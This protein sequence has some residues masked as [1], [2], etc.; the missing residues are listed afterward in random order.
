M[1]RIGLIDLDAEYNK[2]SFPNLCLMKISA[3]W[4]KR[5]AVVEWYDA[6][7]GKYDIVYISK[8]FS[9][10]P[11]TNEVINADLVYKG[12]T[13]YSIRLINSKEQY[14]LPQARTLRLKKNNIH[15]LYRLPEQIE[16]IYPDY[17]IYKGFEGKAYGYLTRGC[18]RNCD[19][20]HVGQKEGLKSYKVANLCD[21][22]RGQKEI[23]LLDP[24]ILAC[25]DWKPLLQQLIDSKAY[26]DF[27]QGLDI[28]LMTK[29]KAEM[30]SQIHC[31]NIHFAWDR[32]ED[33][34]LV[35][36]K[37]KLFAKYRFIAGN[38]PD[39]HAIVYVLVNNGSDFE[40]EDLQRIYMLRELGYWAYV[41]IYDKEHADRKYI[42]LQRWVNNRFVFDTVKR[43]EDYDE[44]KE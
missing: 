27:S 5:K 44:R 38:N 29:E 34:D 4:K 17:S 24:N 42:R 35:L 26:V 12:G 11:D 9:F 31:K 23:V 21:F 25:K 2:V 8:V 19:F 16:H 22:W 1:K 30:I 37:L 28:R 18:P 32:W 39:H 3:Y 14:I 33:K 36:P 7:S 15:Y 6:F 43:F 41:M 10:T 20:C 13:G 40:K